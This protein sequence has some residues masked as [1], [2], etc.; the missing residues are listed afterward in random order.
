M[1]LGPLQ[2]GL[3][4]WLKETQVFRASL[5]EANAPLI[6]EECIEAATLN[7]VFL[8]REDSQSGSQVH[9]N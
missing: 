6:E 7:S 2:Y 5:M 9:N 3:R 4:E 1:K 8:P